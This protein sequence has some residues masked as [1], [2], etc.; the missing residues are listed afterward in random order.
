LSLRVFRGIFSGAARNSRGAS[1][2]GAASV[3]TRTPTFSVIWE[4]TDRIISSEPSTS[5]NT[6]LTLLIVPPVNLRGRPVGPV[7]RR[8][9][10]R[11]V[12]GAGRQS[13]GSSHL[14]GPRYTQLLYGR[15][16]FRSIFCGGWCDR[17]SE[18]ILNC[19]VDGFERGHQRR[20]ALGV[21]GGV[22]PG[23]DLRHKL[24]QSLPELGLTSA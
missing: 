10:P 18:H 4:I 8:A 6:T 19:G 23:Q 12:R 2:T 5:A 1:T 7:P 13:L 21:A 11:L 20:D 14:T 3:T 16:G 17:Q 9:W 22:R 15:F 24:N